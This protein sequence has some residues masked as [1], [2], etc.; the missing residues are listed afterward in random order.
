MAE[1]R[2]STK[3]T[4]TNDDLRRTRAAL[5][6]LAVELEELYAA[7]DASW[8]TASIDQQTEIERL[9]ARLAQVRVDARAAQLAIDETLRRRNEP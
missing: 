6:R 4:R 2:L 3:G 5:E 7:I 9:H 8:N 1:L